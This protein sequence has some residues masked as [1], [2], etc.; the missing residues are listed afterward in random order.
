MI[1]WVQGKSLGIIWPSKGLATS[2]NPKARKKRKGKGKVRE[3]LQRTQEEN[4]EEIAEGSLPGENIWNR[5]EV[6]HKVSKVSCSLGQE[7]GMTA[8]KPTDDVQG[9]LDDLEGNE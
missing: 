2:E 4:H 5:N 7:L 6:I 9:L 3:A 1:K 8:C